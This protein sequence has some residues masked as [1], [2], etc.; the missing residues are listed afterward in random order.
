[1]RKLPDNIKMVTSLEI[2][3]AEIKKQVIE[4]LKKVWYKKTW[5]NEYW[6]TEQ[7]VYYKLSVDTKLDKIKTKISFEWIDDE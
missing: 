6:D 4:D 5:T 7:R 3:S 1:M 2:P